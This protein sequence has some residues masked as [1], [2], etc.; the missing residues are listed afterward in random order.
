M[1][2]SDI[3]DNGYVIVDFAN[4]ARAML[5]LCM[6]A[7]GR[8]YQEEISRGGPKG[9]IEAFVPGPGRFWPDDLGAAPV[10]HID[11]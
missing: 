2:P 4:G 9:K 8:D 10:P 5:E 3:W 6:F 11:R 1:A 7:E